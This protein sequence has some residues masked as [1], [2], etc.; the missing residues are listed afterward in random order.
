MWG[1]CCKRL[2]FVCDALTITYTVTVD[3]SFIRIVRAVVP[4]ERVASTPMDV[5]VVT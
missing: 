5:R 4:A 2:Y 1:G 3:L